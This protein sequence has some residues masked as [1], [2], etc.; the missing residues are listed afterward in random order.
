MLA[1]DGAN[2]AVVA[3][4]NAASCALALSDIPWNGP[5]AAVRLGLID[6]EV[7]I[8]PTRK[9]LKDSLLNLV[10]TATSQKTIMMLEAD[11]KVVEVNDLM[12]VTGISQSTYY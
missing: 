4:I 12:K 8:N 9:V 6:G 5:V 11:A 10:L 3:A 2:D 7:V 1:D